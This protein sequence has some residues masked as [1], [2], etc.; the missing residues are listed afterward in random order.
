MCV[1]AFLIDRFE[2]LRA[3][4]RGTLVHGGRTPFESIGWK[5]SDSQ[6]RVS[7]HQPLLLLEN[8]VSLQ[9]TSALKFKSSF[10]CRKHDPG[11][12]IR[13]LETGKPCA[14]RFSPLSGSLKSFPFSRKCIHSGDEFLGKWGIVLFT[15]SRQ[16]SALITRLSTNNWTARKITTN[17]LRLLT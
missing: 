7:H 14:S 12:A 16:N 2:F 11:R 9:F 5:L 10:K 1:F 13:W 15:L 17:F 8:L 6:K 4:Q 3:R